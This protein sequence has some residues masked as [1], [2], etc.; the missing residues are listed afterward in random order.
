MV[1]LRII[2]FVPVV[3]DDG[4]CEPWA[5]AKPLAFGG[6][7]RNTKAAKQRAERVLLLI[8]DSFC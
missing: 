5:C 2:C 1:V 8:T 7:T 3:N 6:A 4:E